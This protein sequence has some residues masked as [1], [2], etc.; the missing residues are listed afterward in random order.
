MAKGVLLDPQTARDLIK[1]K[2]MLEASQI[3]NPGYIEQVV[4]KVM[5]RIRGDEASAYFWPPSG[6]IPAAT[7][8]TTDLTAGA[9]DCYV[10]VMTSEGVYEKGTATLRVENIVPFVVGANGLPIKATRNEYGCYT[11]DVEDCS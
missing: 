9:A 5:P 8:S 10:A 11:V 7:T 2:R 6:G 3:L 1:F 4:K